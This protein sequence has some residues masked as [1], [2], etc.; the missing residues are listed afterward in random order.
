M[1]MCNHLRPNRKPVND[2]GECMTAIVAYGSQMILWRPA[3]SSPVM[4]H[5][6]HFP[7]VRVG[8]VGVHDSYHKL[9]Q[10]LNSG[11]E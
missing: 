4:A 2:H 9:E 1:L 6:L 10:H 11:L 8:P 5:V 3:C 7:S